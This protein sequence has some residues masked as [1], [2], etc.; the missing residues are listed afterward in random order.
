MFCYREGIDSRSLA[1][2][3][4]DLMPNALWEGQVFRSGAWRGT[5]GGTAPVI[6][7]ATE[8]VL[9][10]VGTAS[11]RDVQLA[12]R[13]AAKAQT[14]WAMAS[15]SDRAAILARVASV[16]HAHHEELETWLVREGG[17]TF[18]KASAELDATAAE[19]AAASLLAEHDKQV[20]LPSDTGHRS[21][22][23]RM[24]MGVVGV[25]TPWNMPLL[26]AMRSVAP[27]LATGNAVVLKPDLQTAVCGGV[28]VTRLFEVAG[29]PAG[30]LSM[31]P[32]D[33]TAGE[34][35]VADPKVAM[36]SFTGSSATGRRVA[37]LGGKLLKR[38][39]LELGGN[40]AFIVLDDAD[41][42]RASSCGA[43]SSFLHQ[44][45]ICLAAGRHIVH[46][47]VAEAYVDALVR[48]AGAL[49]VG[50]P[51]R[52]EVDLGPLIS[53]RQA[54][55]VVGILDRSVAAGAT[56]RVG[57]AVRGRFA[58]PTVVTEVRPSMP[59]WRDEIFGPVAP[60]VAVANDDDAL[61]MAN[62]TEYGLVA[63]VHS[64]N[65]SRAA[66]LAA[67]L[68]TGMVHINDRTIWDEAEA[69]FGGVGASGNGSRYG[70][71]ANLETF[72]QW[73]WMT[74]RDEAPVY[75]F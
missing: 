29:L 58:D 52:E 32:G 70:S 9:G 51:F 75:P 48:R 37:E 12:C 15:G 57:G 24:P 72:T 14:S 21:S 60:V 35:V 68:R 16:L 69:P 20:N 61:A 46:E 44:G 73:R 26:L 41:I 55:R 23:R 66:R 8:S 1:A 31:L 53:D 50:D 33:S 18:S 6:E 30:V 64:S 59:V 42:D 10:T 38:V 13:A 34:A 36:V 40:N 25:I 3:P 27:A 45:Q 28:A 2:V 4:R 43:W 62:D 63:A 56:I 39:S 5:D 7:K 54:A 71:V 67:R 17:G 22:C 19:V 11:R 74:A 49:R 47:S 65:P